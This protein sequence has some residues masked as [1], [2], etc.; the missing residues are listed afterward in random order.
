MI[1]LVS[2]VCMVTGIISTIFACK[3]HLRKSLGVAQSYMLERGKDGLLASCSS[4]GLPV[5]ES[6][7]RNQQRGTSSEMCQES[8]YRNEILSRALSHATFMGGFLL[9]IRDR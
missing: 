1:D 3:T 4:T 8:Q 2:I 5:P 9:D 6:N 7:L